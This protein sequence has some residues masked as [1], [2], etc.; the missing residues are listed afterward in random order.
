MRHIFLGP[1]RVRVGVIRGNFSYQPFVAGRLGK[2]IPL[3]RDLGSTE[4]NET[5]FLAHYAVVVGENGDITVERKKTS[6]SVVG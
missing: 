4:S 3:F 6:H 5:F 2:A 1:T